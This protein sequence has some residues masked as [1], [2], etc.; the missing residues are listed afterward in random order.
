MTATCPEYYL[1]LPPPRGV[2]SR[3]KASRASRI[4]IKKCSRQPGT[5][6]G[7]GML[8]CA[9]LVLAVVWGL[10]TIYSSIFALGKTQ[11]HSPCLLSSGCFSGR[12]LPLHLS[13]SSTQIR[14]HHKPVRC[15]QGHLRWMTSAPP[16]G[17]LERLVGQTP[18][19][20]EKRPQP[21]APLSWGEGRGE[22]Q[23]GPSFLWGGCRC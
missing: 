17:G 21:P 8:S 1:A 7:G 5:S 23:K 16:L 11:Q 20:R 2:D 15:R 6:I 9:L 14:R 3:R 13:A 19:E 12:S 10:Y 18:A 4:N 22:G